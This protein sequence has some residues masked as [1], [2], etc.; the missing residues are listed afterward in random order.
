MS[1]SNRTIHRATLSL[2]FLTSLLNSTARAQTPQKPQSEEVL[3]VKTELVQTA[4]TVV[5]KNGRFIDGLHRDQFELL[6]DGKPR[7]IGF[8]ER[9]TAG[10]AREEQVVTGNA[11]APA[12]SAA[13]AA[14]ADAVVAGRTIVFFIDDLH[15]DPDSLHRTRDMLRYF[16]ENEMSSAD[17]VAIT[18]ASG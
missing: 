6:V 8:F 1:S 13:P 7:S 10:S 15:L 9:L 2:I 12:G 14:A 18:S 4:I 16:L 5:D 17:S 3:R 11:A